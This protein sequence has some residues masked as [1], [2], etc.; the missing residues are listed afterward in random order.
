MRNLLNIVSH[1]RSR[2]DSLYFERLRDIIASLTIDSDARMID[3]SLISFERYRGIDK[4]RSNLT[5][6][7]IVDH[8]HSVRSEYVESLTSRSKSSDREFS[9]K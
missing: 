9:S 2:H 6:R 4:R 8:I 3:S 1:I 7:V 5:N